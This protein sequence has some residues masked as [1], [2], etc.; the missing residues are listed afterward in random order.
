MRAA[1]LMLVLAACAGDSVDRGDAGAPADA[2]GQQVCGDNQ[3]FGETQATCCLDCGCPSGMRCSGP[4]GC[5]PDVAMCGDNMCEAPETQATCCLDCGCAAGSECTAQGCVAQTS[6]GDGSCSNGESSSTCCEDCP[7][8]QGLM[9]VSHACV[10]PATCGD[11]TCSATE[12]G[13]CCKDCGCRLGNL[14]GSDGLCKS[15]GT[16][17]LTWKTMDNCLNNENVQLRF[18]DRDDRLAWPSYTT[19][20]ILEPG[21]SYSNGLTCT[22]GARICYGANQPQHKLYWGVDIDNSRT[23]TNCCYVCDTKEASTNFTCP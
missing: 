1:L 18:F 10:D 5:V 14:C 8:A 17:T 13:R 12:T 7:C 15:V 11:G 19:V 2:P 20:Y 21:N 4:G 6:C 22:K 9:C 16:A 3:C 23:C